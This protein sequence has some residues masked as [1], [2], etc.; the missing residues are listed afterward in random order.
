MRSLAVLV[1]GI[2]MVFAAA[3]DPAMAQSRPMD[4][5]T[6]DIGNLKHSID[7]LGKPEP[8]RGSRKAEDPRPK[9][10]EKRQA[11]REKR[12]R[13]ATTR[14]A[15][16]DRQRQCGAQWREARAAGRLPRGMTWPRYWSQCNARLKR[17]G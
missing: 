17:A 1:L 12:S 16:H 4:M 2:T 3:N 13:D 14:S 8:R 10:S 5:D 9:R 11:R 7:Q 15:L 6:D